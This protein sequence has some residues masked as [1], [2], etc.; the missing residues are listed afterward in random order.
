MFGSYE[1]DGYGADWFD[2]VCGRWLHV[3]CAEDYI[4][5]C[6]G[7]KHYCPSLLSRWFDSA[8][9]VAVVTSYLYIH[10]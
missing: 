4:T 3:D 9:K 2:C 7:N 1:L 6:H 8:D 10:L 5:D